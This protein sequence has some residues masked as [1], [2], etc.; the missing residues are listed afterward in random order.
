MATVSFRSADRTLNL[1]GKTGLKNFIAGLF[2]REQTSLASLTYVFCSD[3]YLLR[4]NQDFLQH[5]Y[6]TDIISF[7][8]TEP[9]GKKEAEIYVSLDRV[10]DNARTLGIP[11]RTE[12]YRVLFHGALHI[13][14]YKDKKK[15][16]IA[17]MR[18]KEEQ[19]LRLFDKRLR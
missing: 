17:L 2:K 6:Y 13:C 7:D 11:F 10:K 12:L 3:D 5:D 9:G 4:I 8:L 1:P 19:Y 16:E 15:S 14:G 18:E